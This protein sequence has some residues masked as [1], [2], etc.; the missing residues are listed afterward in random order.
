MYHTTAENLPEEYET[1]LYHFVFGERKSYSVRDRLL[2]MGNFPKTAT[3]S[4]Q[5]LLARTKLQLDLNAKTIPSLLD[6][7]FIASY[8][9]FY[10]FKLSI[11]KATNL[12]SR[13]FPIC[14]VSFTPNYY[15]PDLELPK[16][17]FPDDIV[18][19]K[20]ILNSEMR[21]PAWEDGFRWYRHRVF[22]PTMLAVI[23]IFSI[24]PDEEGNLETQTAG[25]T[26]CPIF[27]PNKYVRHGLFQLPI[28]EASP[29][30]EAIEYWK[31]GYTSL[32]DAIEDKAIT[33]SRKY[34][35]LFVR[36]C[37]GRRE[38]ELNQNA[39][40]QSLIRPLFNHIWDL[41][42]QSSNQLVIPH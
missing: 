15:D 7:S 25:W 1:N 27:H 2:S 6:L 41:W 12:N 36:L 13:G 30:P 22:D 34:P 40:I 16:I 39:V 4:E 8:D 20:Q 14:V 33:V 29:T 10:G 18:Y 23:Q 17:K 32:D 35:S 28:F 26:I 19:L 5:G 9:P 31:N 42:H 11:D 24:S 21:H 37:D 3:H 38:G